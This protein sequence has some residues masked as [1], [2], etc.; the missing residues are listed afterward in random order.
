MNLNDFIPSAPCPAMAAPARLAARALVLAAFLAAVLGG[1]YLPLRFDA[2]VKITRG[3]YYEMDYDGYLVWVPLY[4][5]LRSGKISP[6]KEKEKVAQLTSDLTRDTAITDTRYFKQG[7]FRLRWKKSGDLLRAKSVTF[8]R[9]NET[10][11]GIKYVKTT[12]LITLRGAGIGKSALKRLAAMG[13]GT[14]GEL[15]VKTDLPIVEHNAT[16]VTG[17]VQKI[18]TWKIRS[19][20]DPPPKLVLELR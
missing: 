13:L 10:F 11:I 18:L 6:A 19:L 14:E 9:R 5:G 7:R 17:G 3:G 1:C 2:E 20:F 4:E 16:R 8:L 15:R 12:G